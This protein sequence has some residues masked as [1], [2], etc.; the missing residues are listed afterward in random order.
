M[1]QALAV[2][3]IAAVGAWVALQQMHIAHTKLQHDLYDRRYAVFRAVRRFLDEA[4]TKKFVSDDT[5]RAFVL[6]TADAAFLFDNRL[7]DDLMQMSE[8]ARS[9]QSICMTMEHLPDGEIKARASACRRAAIVPPHG[10]GSRD[11]RSLAGFQRAEPFG[12]SLA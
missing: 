10:C 7:A 12:L 9:A 4:S 6:G 5:L 2:P 8:R 11:L 1:L 3:V